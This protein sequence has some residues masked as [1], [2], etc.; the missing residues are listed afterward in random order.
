MV[1]Y[2]VHQANASRWGKAVAAATAASGVTAGQETSPE[3][4]VPDAQVL[5]DTGSERITV[6]EYESEL[7]AVRRYQRAVFRGTARVQ[8]RAGRRDVRTGP[9][10][11]RGRR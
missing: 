5:G 3:P 10:S 8:Q 9:F 6:L 1:T 4:D 2:V 11:L 7:G